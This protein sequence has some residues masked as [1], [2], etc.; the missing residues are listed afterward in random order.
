MVLP[1]KRVGAPCSKPPAD[2]VRSSRV[3]LAVPPRSRGTASPAPAQLRPP[4]PPG[5]QRRAAPRRRGARPASAASSRPKGSWPR[6][7]RGSARRCRAPS[8]AR[9][10]T[11]RARRRA[12]PSGDAQPADRARA[13]VGDDVAEHVLGH[14]HVVEVGLLQQVH[15]DRVGVG[16]VDLDVGVVGGH[17]VAHGA[18]EG[19]AAQDVGLVAHRHAA[20]AVA[21]RAVARR[22]RSNAKRATRSRPCA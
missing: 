1:L 3:Q 12:R 13:E 5:R 2:G 4:A 21:R 7:W 16:V 19:V 18:E 22:A 17:L 10:G 20:L 14:D 6:G 9:P 8:R 11:G 15:G